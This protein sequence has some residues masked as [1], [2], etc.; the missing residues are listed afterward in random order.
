[1][2]NVNEW[3]LRVSL[4]ELIRGDRVLCVQDVAAL[5]QLILA[6]LEPQ[7]TILRD[8]GRRAVLH[9]EDRHVMPQ[10]LQLFGHREG[11]TLAASQP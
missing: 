2:G 9:S 5:G 4:S 3:C 10:P 1:M 7:S 6:R 11:V 8:L